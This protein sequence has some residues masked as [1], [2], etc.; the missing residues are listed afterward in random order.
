MRRLGESAWC[1]EKHLLLAKCHVEET[2]QK[3]YR[4]RTVDRLV[5]K[6]LKEA[7][8]HLAAAEEHII[9]ILSSVGEG[10]LSS[11]LRRL[12][13]D[14]RRVR[15]EIANILFMERVGDEELKVLERAV[16]NLEDMFELVRTMPIPKEQ[17]VQISET[18]ETCSEDLGR[19]SKKYES[20]LESGFNISSSRVSEICKIPI[21]LDEVDGVVIYAGDVDV[22]N[23]VREVIEKNEKLRELLHRAVIEGGLY[24][25]VISCLPAN[26][27]TVAFTLRYH[28]GCEIYIHPKAVRELSD[29]ALMFILAHELAHALGHDL[30]DICNRIAIEV[31]GID[32]SREVT[33]P[34]SARLEKKDLRSRAVRKSMSSIL[35]PLVGAFVGKGIQISGKKLTEMIVAKRVKAGKSAQLKMYERPD[36]WFDVG[37]GVGSLVGAVM[38]SGVLEEF[39]IGMACKTVPDLL[40][41]FVE[42]VQTGKYAVGGGETYS[43]ATATFGN[44]A[45]QS[46]SQEGGYVT[47]VAEGGEGKAGESA[48]NVSESAE[49]PPVVG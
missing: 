29:S 31:A 16:K 13:D 22:A 11:S 49:A 48:Q 24:R 42:A 15:Q 14:V 47:V 41:Y 17:E 9:D 23:R 4:A 19:I 2:L 45:Q 27:R 12:C 34:K 3:L 38:T 10:E 5:V 25:I 35:V 37:A 6:E 26:S 20:V 8:K 21:P 33:V 1:V 40:D 30:E 39:F 28:D 7:V 36:F 18:C 32:A 46:E 43:E 44:E